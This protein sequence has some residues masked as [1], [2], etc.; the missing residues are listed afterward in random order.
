MA[1]PGNVA[2][3]INGNQST[4]ALANGFSYMR[5]GT[6]F[7]GCLVISFLLNLIFYDDNNGLKLHSSEL[8][9]PATSILDNGFG[10]SKVDKPF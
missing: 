2:A 10:F 1:P 8:D 9:I 4:C 5:F 6:N 3:V 7:I